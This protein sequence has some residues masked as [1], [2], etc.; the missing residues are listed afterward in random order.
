MHGSYKQGIVN[1][2]ELIYSIDSGY[3]LA[4]QLMDPKHWSVYDV[5]KAVWLKCHLMVQKE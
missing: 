3:V 1:K 4:T 2:S 5:D